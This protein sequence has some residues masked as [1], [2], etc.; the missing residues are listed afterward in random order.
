MSKMH[1][2]PRVELLAPV[3]KWDVLETVIRAGADAV[4]LG[5][6]KFNMRLHRKDFNLTDEELQEAAIYC[7]EKGVK[8]YVTVNNL[9]TGK[10]TAELPGYLSFLEEIA[11]DGLIVQD[12]GVVKLAKEMGLTVPSN[13]V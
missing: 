9:L 5:G 13:P 12:L 2:P 6:K 8:I 1:E 11:V 10:E 4:Y 3:G 7:H